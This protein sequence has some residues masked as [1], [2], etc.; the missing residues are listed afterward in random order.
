MRGSMIFFI[1]GCP[2]TKEAGWKPV[3]TVT[4]SDRGSQRIGDLTEKD[5]GFGP[6]T[7]GTWTQN[8]VLPGQPTTTADGPILVG[9]DGAGSLE[10]NG[11][12]LGSLGGKVTKTLAGLL[13]RPNEPSP[14]IHRYRLGPTRIMALGRLPTLLSAILIGTNGTTR[15]TSSHPSE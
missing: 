2:P 1:R 7:A 6:I 4:V 3:I 14:R 8:N 10:I 13:F 15:S 9:P 5:T 11:L 12:R